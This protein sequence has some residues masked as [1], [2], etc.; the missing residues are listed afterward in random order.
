MANFENTLNVHDGAAVTNWISQINAGGTVYD[1]A[2][3][4]SIKF[5]E[6]NEETTWNGLSDLTVVIP[7]IQDI[8][9]TP[10]EFAGTVGADGNVSW[11]ATHTDGPQV[12]YLVFVTADCTF[13]D[14]ACEAGDMA[15]YDGT[16][17]NI[18]S[19]ENQVKIVAAADGTSGDA[20]NT[21]TVAVGAAKNVLTVEGKTLA[22][23][24]DYA[25]LNN[26]HLTV[27]K[28]S[29][30]DVSVE[31][32]DVTVAGVGLKL[33][34]GDA[35]PTTIGAT[36]TFVEAT[37][38]ADGTVTLT[39]ADSLVREVN[40]GTFTPGTLPEGKKNTQKTLA[41]TGGSVVKGTG[42]DFV[43]NVTFGNVTFE[44]AGEGDTNKITAI[45][46]VTG[47][48]EGQEFYKGIHLTKEDETA[49]ITIAGA[50][51]P[52][53]GVNTTF[54]DGLAD[55]KTSVLTGFTEGSFGFTTGAKEVVTGFDGSAEVIDTVTASV[56]ST[57]NVLNSAYVENNVLH[58]G[59]V[60][61]ASDVAVSTTTRNLQLTKTGYSYESAKATSSNLST[62]GFTQAEGV[63][64]TFDKANETIYTTE[65]G[66]WK[67]N[68][69]Q[70][71]VDKGAYT[72]SNTGMIATVD[73]GTFVE[74]V[75]GGVLPKWEGYSAPTVKVEG[76]VGTAL[77]T[78]EISIIGLNDAKINMPGA[79]TL[80]SVE[81]GK[82]D[83]TV[84][85]AGSDVVTIGESSVN[86]K[87]Y[88]TDVTVTIA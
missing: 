39:N 51:I 71:G 63:G 67:L 64:Y 6:G 19:G 46:S 33:N 8:V 3:H 70:L 88:L 41:V 80:A 2:T 50:Y 9:Q 66:M 14:I 40:F 43:T 69:P 36:T 79:Y 10:I 25:D 86:L 52:T 15:I 5:V 17:W 21:H 28:T 37:A 56:K 26:N 48:Q 55:G 38:L 1:I 18:V 35:T 74:S 76:T 47:K 61:V 31:F 44:E 49:D 34:Q 16:K 73:A 23:T 54:V 84:A 32:G 22:L 58:F 78:N 81:A 7:T 4:H 20:A 82:G 29:G 60:D 68:T 12:G 59:N 57:K 53:K 11:N 30:K 77:T 65:T 75:S 72:L 85:A 13:N 42:S 87:G 45:T 27:G 24:L 83:V 62:S